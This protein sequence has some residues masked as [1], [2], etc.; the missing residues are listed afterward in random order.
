[1]EERVILNLLEFR[2]KMENFEGFADFKAL[3][4][5]SLISVPPYKA[6]QKRIQKPI[7]HLRWSI[8]QK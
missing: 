7:K 8:L 5:K 4:H 6:H 3:I 1:M 2:P